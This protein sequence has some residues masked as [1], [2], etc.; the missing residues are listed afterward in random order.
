MNIALYTM[1]AI[2][3][4][5]TDPLSLLMLFILGTI[6]YRQNRKISNMQKMILG[7]EVD[8]ALEL[9]LSQ[10]VIGIIA[11]AIVSIILSYLGVM[12]DENSMI[13]IMFFLSMLFMFINPR[14]VCFSYSGAVLGITSLLLQEASKLMNVPNMDPFK[15]DIVSLMT[16]VAV[17]HLAEGILVMIDGKRGA[18][19]VFTNRDDKIVGGFVFKRYWA[20]PIVLIFVIMSKGLIDSTTVNV[21]TPNW[22]PIINGSMVSML[23]KAIAISMIPFYGVLG[24]SSVTFTKSKQ[25]KSISS[26]LWILG[27]GVALIGIAQLAAFG[28]VFKLIVLLFAPF[29]HELMLNYQKHKEINDKPKYVSEEGLMVLEVCPDS[30]AQKMKIKSGDAILEIN[31]NVIDTEKDFLNSIKQSSNFLFVKV[32]NEKGEMQTLNSSDFDPNKN[33]GIICVPKIIPENAKM[34]NMSESK[35]RDVLDK[36]TN[37]DDKK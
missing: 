2:A 8:S 12:F 23:S 6:L 33:F 7:Q 37:K 22:W 31:E 5:L 17:F 14:Y 26:G 28:V 36:I 21:P 34:V 20:V 11:G 3:Q 13:F 27:Y 1:R 29:G 35:F 19:P 4:L 9:T 32:K 24:Y 25:E 18:I 15:I 16:M 10:V 30:P